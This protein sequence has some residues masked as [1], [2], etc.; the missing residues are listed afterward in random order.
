MGAHSMKY[1]NHI[2]YLIQST[3][4]IV[5]FV[6]NDTPLDARPWVNYQGDSNIG[7]YGNRYLFT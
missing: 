4:Y 6:D 3:I 7:R 2:V 1:H 5:K